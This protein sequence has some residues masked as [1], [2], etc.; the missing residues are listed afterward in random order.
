MP[1]ILCTA[2]LAIVLSVPSFAQEQPP[3]TN[4]IRYTWIVTSCA[5]WNCAAAAL[6]MAD[7]DKYTMALPTGR[8]ERPWLI[9]RRVEDGSIFI[10]EDEPFGCEVF[11]T[12]AAAS[13]H[14]DGLDTCRAPMILSLPDGRAVVTSAY[15][16]AG[17]TSG[18]TRRRAAGGR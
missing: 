11:D 8:E 16:C 14:F 18:A 13:T 7:G 15:E 9:L 10:P 12:V 4:P 17:A 1:R 5:T 3:L 6:V 2:A